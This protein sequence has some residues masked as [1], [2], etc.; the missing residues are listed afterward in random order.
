M[1][2][3]LLTGIAAM[4]S[5][6]LFSQIFTDNFDT[7]TAGQDL[8]SQNPTD[9]DTWTGGAGTTE[10]VAISSAN[11]SSGANSLYFASTGGGPNDI[12]LRFDQEYN[13]GNF[14]LESNFF[15]EAGKGAYFNMQ[16]TFVVGGVWAIDCF[17]L[18]DG[19][20]NLKSGTT[21]NLST[22]YPIAQWFNMRIE[23]DLTANVW[24]LFIDNVS[25]GT[26]S[27]PVGS[28]AILNLYPT[29]PTT[30]GGN[31]VA[32]FYVDDVSFDHSVTSL[33]PVNGGVTYVA[34]IAGIVSQSIAVEGTVRN[35]GTD[36][37][38]SFDIE[39][40]YNG[41]PAVQESVGPVNMASLATYVHTF[42]T[43][44]SL[45]AG[46]LPL[47]VTVSNVNAAGADAS[48]AD[49]ANTI[50]I[51]PIVPA[52]GKMVLGEEATGT[53]CQ[54]CPRGAVFM[55]FMETNYPDHWAGVAVH[56]ADPMTDPVY[57]AGI[58]A[59]IGGYPSSL[60]DRGAEGD[61]STMEA[62]FLNRIIVAPKAFLEN[63]ATYDPST[64]I[65]EVSVT[66]DFQSSTFADWRVGVILT[67]DG[68]TG[69]AGYDQSNAYAGGANGVMG[70]YET[71]P[72]PV[73]AAQM[74]YDHVARAIE[75]SFEGLANSFPSSIPSGL[76]QTN[77]FAFQ[78][79]VD[80]DETKIHII[81]F[82]RNPAGVMDN[83]T[84]ETINSAVA[85]GYVNCA[86]S[87]VHDSSK[88]EAFKL[89][90]NPTNGVTFVDIINNDGENVN[91]TVTDL[92]GKIVAQ[93]DYEVNGAAKLPIVTNE[94][95]KGIYVVTLTIGEV[96]Q[97]QKLIVQ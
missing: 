4:F 81:S 87:V 95:S 82:L 11:A 84:K 58:G 52:T 67:E 19:T 29:N 24:E 51:D 39:Y 46:S 16:E 49:D 42:A 45:A 70:G 40:T 89:F 10:D 68:V 34:P 43:P 69:V 48:S 80:W 3:I 36:P 21:T 33:P 66:A 32:G 71:L 62:T 85:N 35:L 92:T 83:A 96:T 72:N 13:S 88:E 8:V 7:Y 15:V 74:V 22:T 30:E 97:Q 86:T 65:L 5:A 26:F 18:D 61:P 54:W 17:M 37:I 53:W 1:K 77:C 91:V 90:P 23:I 38:T 57:D 64:R 6:T 73:P 59:L 75:P 47:T 94:F 44:I 55:D 60:V 9:W 27:N 2:R 63:G 20:F 50:T 56:N 28:I 79:P 14:T 25:Q 12:I 78:L 93:R 31:D 41:M 76:I